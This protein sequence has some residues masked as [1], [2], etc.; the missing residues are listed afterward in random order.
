M[1]KTFYISIIKVGNSLKCLSPIRRF[2]IFVIFRF[3]WA[4]IVKYLAVRKCL[5]HWFF[6]VKVGDF[7]VFEKT[8]VERRLVSSGRKWL[9]RRNAWKRN[10]PKIHAIFC[11]PTFGIPENRQ[12]H[13]STCLLPQQGFQWNEAE[14]SYGDQN[15]DMPNWSSHFTNVVVLAWSYL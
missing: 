6:C 4:K 14:P 9:Q 3:F 5:L 8:A 12:W 11:K 15:R 1:W 7:K 10:I 13:L 2:Y